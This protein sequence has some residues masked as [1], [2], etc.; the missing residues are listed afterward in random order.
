MVGGQSLARKAAA[1]SRKQEA[2]SGELTASC[3]LLRQR[4]ESDRTGSP[5][6]VH[7]RRLDVQIE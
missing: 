1:G 3:S 7:P 2:G 6:V 5:R 4:S